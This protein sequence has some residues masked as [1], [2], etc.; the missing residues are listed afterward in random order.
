MVI[1]AA[2]CTMIFIVMYAP[3]QLLDKW[4]VDKHPQHVLHLEY[5]WV[6]TRSDSSSRGVVPNASKDLSLKKTHTN[7]D[8]SDLLTH[9]DLLA[10]YGGIELSR[11]WLR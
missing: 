3:G 10:S 6:K 7:N 11:H 8:V 4:F 1:C 9:C 2:Q 5:H